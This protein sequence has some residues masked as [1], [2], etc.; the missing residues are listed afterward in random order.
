MKVRKRTPMY[1]HGE[2][3]EADRSVL[4]GE[5]RLGTESN[6]KRKILLF[7]VRRKRKKSQR[8]V[9]FRGR[10]PF[11]QAKEKSHL[12]VEKKSTDSERLVLEE[13]RIGEKGP[14]GK[15]LQG[16][17]R[18]ILWKKKRGACVMWYSDN[19]I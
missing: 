9:A 12:S 7:P 11:L 16:G 3:R 2:K 4:R 10:C 14:R 6:P 8:K 5:R 15:G 19:A 13:G 18:K 1:T 17:S